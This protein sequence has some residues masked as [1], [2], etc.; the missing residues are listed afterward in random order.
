MLLL[1]ALPIP[2]QGMFVEVQS[3]CVKTVMTVKM[4]DALIMKK[5]VC[6]FHVEIR[7]CNKVQ[8]RHSSST[9]IVMMTVAGVFIPK[10]NS[11]GKKG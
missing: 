5:N 6:R 4:V 7:M 1:N 10:I 3:I 2:Q 11:R 8:T 9:G